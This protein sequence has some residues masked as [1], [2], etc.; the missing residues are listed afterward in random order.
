MLEDGQAAV[1]LNLTFLLDPFICSPEPVVQLRI[2]TAPLNRIL[3]MSQGQE[4]SKASRIELFAS[5]PSVQH[6]KMLNS[7]VLPEVFPRKILVFCPVSAISTSVKR[8]CSNLKMLLTCRP[9]VGAKHRSPD[10]YSRI[11]PRFRVG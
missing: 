2:E 5:S 9:S 10:G 6:Y 1:F 11:K 4:G 8:C 3:R 7:R